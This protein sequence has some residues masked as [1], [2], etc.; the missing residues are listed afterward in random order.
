MGVKLLFKE[1]A[2]LH[3]PIDARSLH[4]KIWR[5]GVDMSGLLHRLA[6]RGDTSVQLLQQDCTSLA[7]DVKKWITMLAAR[8][9]ENGANAE[10]RI[11]CVFDGPPPGCK[12]VAGERQAKRTKMREMAVALLAED[13]QDNAGAGIG[14]QDDSG[15]KEKDE[16]KSEVLDIDSRAGRAS[17]LKKAADGSIS[18]TMEAVTAVCAAIEKIEFVRIVFSPNEADSEMAHMH[19]AG[20]IDAAVTEDSDLVVLAVPIIRC[21][22]GESACHGIALRLCKSSS[23]PATVS[24]Y[25][26]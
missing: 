6:T 7:R 5:V 2:G 8:I 13:G 16:D 11:Y 3:Q 4:E 17:L 25:A 1:L 20:L 21:L 14:D 24:L 18:I 12:K 23:G 10:A 19:K 9:S 22:R 15:D 26:H